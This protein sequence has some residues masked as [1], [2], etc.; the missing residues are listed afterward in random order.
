MRFLEDGHIPLDN[1]F[2]ER[3][4]KPVALL[5]NASL[6][7]FSIQGAESSMIVHS[8]METAKANGADGYAKNFA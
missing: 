3:C 4:I 5:R 8:L 6:F 2:A 1:G 7:S